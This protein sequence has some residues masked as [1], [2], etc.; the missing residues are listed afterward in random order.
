MTDFKLQCSLASVL[1]RG[2]AVLWSGV[3]G[4][5]SSSDSF[6]SLDD[7]AQRA[8]ICFERLMVYNDG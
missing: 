3:G 5:P 1:G 2:E 4:M 8:M 7:D 6:S